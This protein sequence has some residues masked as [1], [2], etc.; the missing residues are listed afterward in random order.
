MHTT[1]SSS[2]AEPGPSP[3][4]AFQG[5]IEPTHVPALY[6]IGLVVVAFVMVLLPAIYVSL[7]A[8]TAWLVYR[9]AAANYHLLSDKGGWIV[10]LGPI[11]I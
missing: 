11:V 1:N 5:T 6:R 10:Y 8:A 4:S 7:I 9:H 3:L 2:A